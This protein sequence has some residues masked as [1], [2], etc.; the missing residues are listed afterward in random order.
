MYTTPE[1]IP[2]SHFPPVTLRHADSERRHRE[3]RE[4]FLS[5][6]PSPPMPRYLS[7]KHPLTHPHPDDLAL[8]YRRVGGNPEGTHRPDFLDTPEVFFCS[9]GGG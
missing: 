8:A 1:M 2:D 5:A 9:L 6:F 3:R 7:T 4:W